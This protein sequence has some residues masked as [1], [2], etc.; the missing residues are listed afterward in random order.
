MY[1]STLVHIYCTFFMLALSVVGGIRKLTTTIFSLY[2]YPIQNISSP[3]SYTYQNIINLSKTTSCPSS[4]KT[5]MMRPKR[6]NLI[7]FLYDW[8]MMMIR[9]LTLQWPV[10]TVCTTFNALKFCIMPTVY[11]RFVWFPRPPLW[12]SGQSSW[13]QIQKFWFYSRRY[14]IFWEVV[15]LERGP[16]SLVSTILELLERKSSDSGLEIREYGRR[17]SVTLTTWHSVHKSWH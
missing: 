1:L 16:L 3:V 6:T 10:V 8:M 17:G 14:Q 12:S 11:L 2:S 13:L 7:A 9:Y 15:G 5:W 4:D